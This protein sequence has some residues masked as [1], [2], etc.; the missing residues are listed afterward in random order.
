VGRQGVIPSLPDSTALLSAAFGA[1]KGAAPEAVST[2][3]GYAV[4]QVVD[5]Q[6]AHAPA[7][8]DYK[9][10]L[11]NDYRAEKT[12]ELLNQQLI[13]LADRAKVL[14]DLHKAAAEMKL[15]IKTSDLVG[16]DAQVTDIGAMSGAASVAFTLPKGGISGPVNE[17]INGTVLQVTD[18]QEPGA[19]EIAKNFDATKE[20]LLSTKRQEAFSVFI[21]SLMDKYTKAGAINYTK[22]QTSPL[23]I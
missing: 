11:L 6:S 21:G 10:Q 1:A 7:F 8:A 14:G 19:D 16:R 22:K 4:F 13:K 3:E 20:K 2:G 15:E 12:P 5:V 23:G 18:K 17:G 9:G